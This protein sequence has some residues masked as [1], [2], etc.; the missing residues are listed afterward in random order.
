[1]ARLGHFCKFKQS[2]DWSQR[3]YEQYFKFCNTTTSSITDDDLLDGDNG[4]LRVLKEGRFV[5]VAY[6]QATR[7]G[8]NVYLTPER[9]ERMTNSSGI[10]VR[11]ESIEM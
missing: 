4:I 3:P 10:L 6:G 1:M 7:P 8:P 9:S 11:A 5:Y 2:K